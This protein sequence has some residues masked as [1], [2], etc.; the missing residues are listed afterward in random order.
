MQ[1][2]HQQSLDREQ[3]QALRLI[4][5]GMRSYTTAACEISANIEPLELRGKEAALELY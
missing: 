3:N 2:E 1:Q 5:G 4:K